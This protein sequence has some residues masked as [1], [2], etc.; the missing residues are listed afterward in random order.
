M[1]IVLLIS[2]AKGSVLQDRLPFR[3]Q[4]QV[5]VLTWS[6]EYCCKFQVPMI[7]VSRL[8]N[9]LGCLTELRKNFYLGL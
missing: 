2:Q 3:H 4:F 7:L 6:S 1:V 5:Q 9:L 8:I